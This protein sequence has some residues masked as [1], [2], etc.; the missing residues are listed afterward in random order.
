MYYIV[1]V[2]YVGRALTFE[3]VLEKKTTKSK[4]VLLMQAAPYSI[5]I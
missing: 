3:D 5:K 2:S 4:L 1:S